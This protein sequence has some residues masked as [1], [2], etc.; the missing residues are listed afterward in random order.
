MY[1]W[2][3]WWKDIPKS[4]CLVS[5]SRDNRLQKW[6]PK[7]IKNTSRGEQLDHSSQLS[8]TMICKTW[9]SIVSNT[10]EFTWPSGEIARYNTLMVWP[11]RV[12]SCHPQARQKKLCFEQSNTIMH[13]HDTNNPK[14]P[15]QE[16]F[17][18]SLHFNL[19]QL[20]A[21]DIQTFDIAG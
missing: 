14:W 15:A 4:Q 6:N 21:E 17:L 19:Q 7:T 2:L 9:D 10:E 16:R 3:R 11:V 13:A 12:A 1:L 5:S 20:K 8:W 18:T